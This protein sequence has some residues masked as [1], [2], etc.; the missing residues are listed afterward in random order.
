MR[1]ALA[2]FLLVIGGI[3]LA[4]AAEPLASALAAIQPS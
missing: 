2:A 1:R 3:T 4:G